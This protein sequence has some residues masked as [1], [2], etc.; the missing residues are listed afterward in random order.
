MGTNINHMVT[1][2]SQK[3]LN[4]VPIRQN[5]KKNVVEMESSFLEEAMKF[6]TL[7]NSPIYNVK[8]I[9]ER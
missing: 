3:Q 4:Q 1:Q 5:E 9:Q 7:G 2:S 8:N 6:H